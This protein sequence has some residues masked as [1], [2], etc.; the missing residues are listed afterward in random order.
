MITYQAEDYW[1][2]IVAGAF[3]A[4]NVESM[5]WIGVNNPRLRTPRSSVVLFAA[6][7]GD[8]RLLNRALEELSIRGLENEREEVRRNLA[9]WAA[10]SNEEVW[11]LALQRTDLTL[12]SPAA[13]TRHIR[14]SQVWLSG[15]MGNRKCFP[16]FGLKLYVL[17]QS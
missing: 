1:S 16:A 14:I 5:K 3:Q 10:G 7:I 6:R 2:D 4:R 11:K 15:T 9:S 8:I 12:T 17:L 13:W